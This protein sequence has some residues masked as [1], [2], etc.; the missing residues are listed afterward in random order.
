MTERLMTARE[1][2]DSFGFN[3]PGW[4]LAQTRREPDSL[5][6]FRLG[7]D[8]GPVRFRASEVEEW[9]ERR[10][11]VKCERPDQPGRG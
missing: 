4:V 3:G 6:C 11:S 10:R 9:L 1:I 7:V 8:H 5:P 2:A